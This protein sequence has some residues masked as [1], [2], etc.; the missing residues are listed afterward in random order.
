MTLKLVKRYA[1]RMGITFPLTGESLY[2][3]Y[4]NFYQQEVSYAMEAEEVKQKKG[5]WMIIEEKSNI[6]AKAADELAD[7]DEKDDPDYRLLSEMI[8]EITIDP[9]DVIP[10][11]I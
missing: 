2:M 6:F 4:D 9:D 5:D 10:E 11:Y 1:P 8:C 7:F 3:I